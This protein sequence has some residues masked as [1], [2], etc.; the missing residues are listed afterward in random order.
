MGDRTNCFRSCTHYSVP[1]CLSIIL[2]PVPANT[3]ERISFPYVLC[4]QNT[5]PNPNTQ[6]QNIYLLIYNILVLQNHTHVDDVADG[7]QTNTHIK[8]VLPH[9][10]ALWRSGRNHEEWSRLE[11]KTS[12][13]LLCV[14]LDMCMMANGMVAGSTQKPNLKSIYVWWLQPPE[15]M[16]DESDSQRPREVC[17]VFSQLASFGVHNTPH[18][19]ERRSCGGRIGVVYRRHCRH[20]N[21]TYFL[22]LYTNEWMG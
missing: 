11:S 13:F 4:V 22:N 17:L 14:Y 12:F 19:R 21:L 8:R 3:T 18:M 9:N 5:S 2:L 16:G 10:T 15:T 7:D 20:T 6:A 1:C